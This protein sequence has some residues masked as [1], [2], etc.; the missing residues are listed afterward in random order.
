MIEF[1][2]GD[3]VIINATFGRGRVVS[4]PATIVEWMASPFP[5]ETPLMVMVRPDSTGK[6]VGVGFRD[7]DGPERAA[8]PEKKKRGRPRKVITTGVIS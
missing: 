7:I 3:R 6:V 2:P 1:K 8:E 4:G 5:G